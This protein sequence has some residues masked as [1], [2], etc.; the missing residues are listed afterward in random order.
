MQPQ[1]NLL[2]PEAKSRALAAYYGM[3]L[4]D[5]L[6]ATTEFLNADEIQERH[7]V[8]RDLIGGGWLKLR[9]GQVTDDTEMNLYLG[10]A[11]VKERGFN[12]HA[13]AAEFLAW[14]RSKPIDMGSTVRQG[15]R[16]Y[17]VT[18]ELHREPQDWM[19]GNG[20]VMRNLPVILAACGNEKNLRE[21]SLSQAHIT[22]V[23]PE[24]DEGLLLM[25]E[26]IEQAILLGERAPLQTIALRWAE[27]HKRW[28]WR[29]FKRSIDGYVVN[30][31]K[32]ALFYF[33][34]SRDLE[35]CLVGIANAGGDTDTNAAIAGMLAGAFYGMDGLPPRW[36]KRLESKVKDEIHQQ[37]NQIWEI[38]HAPATQ[39]QSA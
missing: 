29:R 33:F 23:H 13:V 26:L 36:M 3:A 25:A 27:Q 39:R 8:H 37:V 7:G 5:A 34:N 35:E 38:Y 6:G 17:L 32:T 20:A 30:S 24:A 11:L 28:D 21:W 15:L 1:P 14:M 10:R 16:Q 12:G 31:V 19:A 22:H 4:G 18:G 9:P 2:G